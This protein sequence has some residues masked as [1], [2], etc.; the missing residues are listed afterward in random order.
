[1]ATWLMPIP[2][3]AMDQSRVGS[4]CPSGIW[5]SARSWW[6]TSPFSRTPL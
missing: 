4:D 1:M 6:L 2:A 3:G 5:A